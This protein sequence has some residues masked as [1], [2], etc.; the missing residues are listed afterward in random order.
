[1]N[2][3]LSALRMSGCILSIETS[4]PR[5][6]VAL[7]DRAGEVLLE[8]TFTSERSHNSQLFAPLGEALE[9]CGDALA[10]IVVGTGPASYTGV[11]IGIAAAQG[12]AMSRNVPLIGLPSVLAPEVA[13]GAGEFLVCGDARRGSFFA[14][15]VRDGALEEG[16]KVRDAAALGV[17]PG[18]TISR[19]PWYTY[20]GKPPLGLEGVICTAPSAARLGLVAARLSGEKVSELAARPLEPL[21]LAAAFITQPRKAARVDGG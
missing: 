13:G 17:L 21:Y 9:A 6:G 18:D 4:T 8:R 2:Q 12:I 3:N 5:G 11:R 1:M 19:M 20:D 10:F 15:I 14:A 7:V 16:V